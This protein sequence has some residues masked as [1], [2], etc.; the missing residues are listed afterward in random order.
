MSRTSIPALSMEKICYSAAK[1]M[2]LCE[3]S[4]VGLLL[5]YLVLLFVLGQ[6]VRTMVE[7]PAR[8]RPFLLVCV[9]CVALHCN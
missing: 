6:V 4:V 9:G 7:G 5:F 8:T 2:I 3:L 1:F